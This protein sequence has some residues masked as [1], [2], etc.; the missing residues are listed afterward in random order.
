MSGHY[1]RL[2]ISQQRVINSNPNVQWWLILSQY[3]C[4]DDINL[5]DLVWIF[6]LRPYEC[7]AS[8]FPTFY[9]CIQNTILCT[10][11][12]RIY[13]VYASHPLPRPMMERTIL[14]TYFKWYLSQTVF[15][16]SWIAYGCRACALVISMSKQLFLALM[17]LLSYCQRFRDEFSPRES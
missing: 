9:P 8:A 16:K 13:S 1:L 17:L 14:I 10:N 15:S 11:E 6:N 5:S 3:F 7:G 12:Y 4:Q 2:N